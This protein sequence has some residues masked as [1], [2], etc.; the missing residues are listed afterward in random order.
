[1]Y[2]Y[3]CHVRPLVSIFY[4]LFIPVFC[5]NSI[6]AQMV[7]KDC[8]NP[9]RF[10]ID[11]EV[12]WARNDFGL[13]FISQRDCQLRQLLLTRDLKRVPNICRPRLIETRDK[14]TLSRNQRT[15]LKTHLGIRLGFYFW[16][17]FNCE[18]IYIVYLYW[19]WNWLFCVNHNTII[20]VLSKSKLSNVYL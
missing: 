11:T 16:S 18:I 15:S 3:I 13:T 4:L 9:G 20:T 8:Q 10:E 6:L 12:T 14:R 2:L 7:A 19:L 1:M 17:F 5:E